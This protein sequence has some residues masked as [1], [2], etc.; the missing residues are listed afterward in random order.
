MTPFWKTWYNFRKGRSPM[1]PNK[2]SPIL[3][4]GAQIASALADKSTQP[5]EQKQP[6]IEVTTDGSISVNSVNSMGEFP[7]EPHDTILY[8]KT[9]IGDIYD[10]SHPEEQTSNT[11]PSRTLSDVA[12]EYEAAVL[13]VESMHNGTEEHYK[14]WLIAKEQWLRSKAAMDRKVEIDVAVLRMSHLESEMA[15]A[16]SA[17]TRRSGALRTK[18][19]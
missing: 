19:V 14:A 15:S 2:Q 9:G 17:M 12:M 13:A 1:S 18:V 16:I 8:P 6:T 3:G 11:R 4:L 7:S 10:A 5:S